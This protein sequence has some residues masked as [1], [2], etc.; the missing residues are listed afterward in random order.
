[1]PRLQSGE[2]RCRVAQGGTIDWGACISWRGQR[3]T[4]VGT[5]NCQV[6]AMGMA[7]PEQYAMRWGSHAIGVVRGMDHG[8]LPSSVCQGARAPVMPRLDLPCIAMSRQYD[9]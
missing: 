4:S 6:L 3:S 5:H 1:M 2:A 8:R 9:L 7:A